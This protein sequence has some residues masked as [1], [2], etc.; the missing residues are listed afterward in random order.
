MPGLKRWFLFLRIPAVLLGVLVFFGFY[1]RFVIDAKLQD[2]KTSLSVLDA[3]AGV[4]QA[5]AALLLVD[6]TLV[7]QMAQAELDLQAV[8]RLQYAQGT[9]AQDNFSRP[10][11]DAQLMVATLAEDRAAARPGLL[12]TLDGL[13]LGAQ[14]AFRQARLLP[15]RVLRGATSDVV[16]EELV[17]EAARFERLGL[18]EKAAQNY[19]TLIRQYPN[20]TGRPGLKLRLGSAYLRLQ[21]LDKAEQTF[22]EAARESTVPQEI[23]AARRM[24]A[25][26]SEARGRLQEAETIEKQLVTLGSGP[27]RQEA[28]YRLGS[29]YIGLYDFRRAAETFRQAREAAPTGR[30][31]AAALFKEGWA[32]R[33]LGR[34]DEAFERFQKLQQQEPDGAF[35]AAAYHQM[36]EAYK[37]T[38]DYE[39]A[40]RS[41]EQIIEKTQDAAFTALTHAQAAA[42]Y[43]FDLK[44]ETRAHIHFQEVAR[45]FPASP[46]AGAE[47]AIEKFRVRKLGSAAAGRP[48]AGLGPRRTQEAQITRAAGQTGGPPGPQQ[49]AQGTPLMNWLENFLPVFVEVFTERLARYMEVADVDEISRRF[50]EEEFNTLVVRRVRERFAGQVTD[51]Q[52]KIREDGYIGSG[53]VKLGLLTFP[54]SARIGIAVENERPI[55]QI[56]EVRVGQLSVPGPLRKI[57]EARVNQSIKRSKYP[58]K[59]KEYELENGYAYISVE[60]AR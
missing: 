52:V 5:E 45:S 51:V 2:L 31:A 24:L 4:G 12:K 23:K 20:Y 28:A 37:A 13:A 11:E 36:A 60:T 50:S 59:I 57:L 58:L 32:L 6:Q 1:N 46:L 55:V 44:D 16:N 42:T 43:R 47:R 19:E 8:A 29:I 39:A 41:Y 21:A 27:R 53:E 34:F 49:L 15:R 48:A 26:I 10:V 25:E 18:F 9:L 3:A 22:R 7:D 33:N 54:V 40:A 14:K 38:G 17:R 30:L 35:A 56:R